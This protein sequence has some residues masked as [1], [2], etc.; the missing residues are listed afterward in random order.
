MVAGHD[1]HI[2]SHKLFFAIQ[3]LGAYGGVE[4]GGA[5]V[6]AGNE[7]CVGSPVVGVVV[8]TRHQLGEVFARHSN[9][10][11]EAAQPQFWHRHGRTLG[12]GCC[13]RHC[14]AQTRGI[15]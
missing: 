14:P 2:A 13:R 10:V 3:Y 15:E 4:L 6:A 12:S 9:D 8:G 7:D 1:E 5:A 11:V